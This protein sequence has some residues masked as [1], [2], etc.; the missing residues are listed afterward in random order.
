[1]IEKYGIAPEYFSPRKGDALIWAANLLHGG[2]RQS[3]PHATRWS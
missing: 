1:M 3:N 2:S